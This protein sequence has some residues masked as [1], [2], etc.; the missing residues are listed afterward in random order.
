MIEITRQ[1]ARTFRAFLRR[2]LPPRSLRG[3]QPPVIVI[4]AERRELRLR[5]HLGDVAVEHRLPG[6]YA[7]DIVSIPL[8]ALEDFEGRSPEKVTLEAVGTDA[9]RASW[10]EGV[11]PRVREYEVKNAS[12]PPKFPEPPDHF[13]QMPTSFL[14][15]LEEARHST[16][17]DAVRY[18]LT[19]I[20]L[21][22]AKNEVVSTDGRELLIQGGIAL[23]WKED[24]LIPGVP[25]FGCRDLS[26]TDTILLGKTATHICF[27]NAAWTV[28]L[29]IDAEGRFPKVEDVIPRLN[30]SV[31]T[32]R[33]EADDAAFLEKT[34]SHLPGQGDKAAPVTL[35]LDGQAAVR[36]RAEGQEQLTEVVLS[37]ST[38]SGPA[39]RLATNRTPLG[40]ALALGF[41][42]F[43]FAGADKPALC[44]SR[45]NTFVWMVLGKDGAL[46]PS[47]D[48]VRIT[49]EPEQSTSK[50][51]LPRNGQ[52]HRERSKPVMPTPL[53][54]GNGNGNVNGKA[55]AHRSPRSA[56]PVAEK[57]A[58]RVSI[59]SLIA[60]AQG[61][62]VS[63]REAH[64]RVNALVAGLR[65]HRQR[66]KAVET[67]LG[68]LKQLQ[69]LGS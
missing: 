30:G 34:L 49:S 48:A 66:S 25:V 3:G 27:Q 36:A 52:P 67:T 28:Y 6:N 44:R 22:G 5:T 32:L 54:N 19:R 56:E 68:A 50:V 24:M 21:R 65:K 43:Q 42:E 13:T 57:P 51:A 7:T 10:Y 35:D 40:R 9:V 58:A 63:L 23:P 59:A 15:V 26:E 11:V 38:V 18:A 2:S 29:A 12:K 45:P 60:E 17:P 69:G 61:I 39:L 8:A 47:S 64:G 53:V 37:R 16:A 62:K 14:Q 31:T 4:E 55:V 41:R 1:F 20:Q 46:G 33:L